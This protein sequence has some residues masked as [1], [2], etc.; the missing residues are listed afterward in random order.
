LLQVEIPDDE[1][2]VCLSVRDPST[3]RQYLLRV[4]PTIGRCDEAAAW[5]AGF[6]NPDDYH[7]IAE[8]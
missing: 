3:G 5:I 2:L 6:D 8:T 4:P 1:P 7:P